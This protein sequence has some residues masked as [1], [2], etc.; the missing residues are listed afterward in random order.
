V[1]GFLSRL[2]ESQFG[3][4]YREGGDVKYYISTGYL[5]TRETVEIARAADELGYDGLGIPDHVVNLETLATRYPYSRDGTRRW[6]P[7]TDWPDPWVLIGSLA[8]CTQRL[9]FVTT[10]TSPRCATLTAPPSRSEQRR[11]SPTGA[12]NSGWAWGGVPRSS[13]CSTRG[14]IGAV[15]EPRR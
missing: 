13:S 2:G 15:G 7:F 8:Q 10:V 11:F 4:R 3:I 9:R 1:S 5:D 12:S 14:S 6:E